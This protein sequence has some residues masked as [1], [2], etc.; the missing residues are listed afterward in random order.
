[1]ISTELG[2]TSETLSKAYNTPKRDVVEFI[3]H[4]LGLT[5]LP[6][7]DDMVQEAFSEFL[8]TKN[9]SADQ[10]M[11]LTIL[12]SVF[13]SKKTIAFRDFYDPPFT[14]LGKPVTSYF[15]K[16]GLLELVKL[17]NDIGMEFDK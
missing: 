4:I 8:I 10:I 14:N 17:C 7:K 12:E 3:K 9:F 15:E 5:K 6:N 1:M 13:I 16:E 11:F 2:I